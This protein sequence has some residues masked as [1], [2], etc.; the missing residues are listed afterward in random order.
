MG[1][2]YSELAKIGR[3]SGYNTWGCKVT[4]SLAGHCEIT[5]NQVSSRSLNSSTHIKKS[6]RCFGSAFITKSLLEALNCFFKFQNFFDSSFLQVKVSSGFHRSPEGPQ[7]YWATESTPLQRTVLGT[8]PKR[9]LVHS[10][11]KS[12]DSQTL[13]G[14]VYHCFW[15][16]SSVVGGLRQI[17][18]VSQI[19]CIQTYCLKMFLK[20]LVQIHTCRNQSL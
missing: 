8:V 14:D 20:F 11:V 12:A 10:R 4:S 7:G 18:G 19:M 2:D 17:G 15:R 5:L 16:K 1:G 3:P 9:S 13:E 6:L